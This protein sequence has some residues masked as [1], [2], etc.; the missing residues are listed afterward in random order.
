[1]WYLHT[2]EFYSATKY[3][4]ISFPEKWMGAG[5][6]HVKQNKP[7]LEMQILLGLFH[8]QNMYLN[9]LA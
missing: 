4:I 1:M 5:D 3:E 9:I 2:V 8:M 6:H 7:D